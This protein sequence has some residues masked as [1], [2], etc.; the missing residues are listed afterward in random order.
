[1]KTRKWLYAGWL[2]AASAPLAVAQVPPPPVVP[3]PVVP[4]VPPP[5]VVPTV[6]PPPRSATETVPPAP[7][8]PTVPPPPQAATGT[9]PPP[10]E[11]PSTPP[12]AP[13]EPAGAAPAAPAGPTF[14]FKLQGE[15][16]NIAPFT[17]GDA[18]TE[19]GKIEVTP[20]KSTL[21]IT[22]TGGVGANVWLGCHSEAIQSFHA[23]EEFEITHS[24]PAVKQMILTLDSKLIGFVR[25]K[26]KATACV[27]LASLTVTPAG[28]STPVLS[29]SHPLP[30]VGGTSH[31][32]D[33]PMG[34]QSKDPIDQIKSQPLP[35]GVYLIDAHFVL[36]ATADG[37]LNAHSTAIFAPEPKELDPWERE[38]DAFVGEKKDGYGFTSVLTATT[39]DAP[40]VTSEQI[41]KTLKKR[42]AKEKKERKE[43]EEMAKQ[44]NPSLAAGPLLPQA[45][46]IPTY[47]PPTVT[48]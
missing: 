46:N 7:V 42:L 23:V 48:R 38:H 34:S 44:Q 32:W 39:V 6:P 8:V 15:E 33:P 31:Y 47:Q 1:M 37:F 19:E 11:A 45:R 21:T 20:D 25:S 36:T 40:T 17:S 43:Q 41:W 12:S 24:D 27:R 2:V 30:C 28:S 5:P 18:K 22:L 26:Q 35:L 3:P 14:E 4:S 10:P 29:V 16:K 13:A 9:V